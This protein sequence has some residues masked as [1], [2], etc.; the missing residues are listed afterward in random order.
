MLLFSGVLHA[1]TDQGADMA[2]VA[3]YDEAASR[4]TYVLSHAFI[5]DAFAGKL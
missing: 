3:R 5:A 4:Q 2:G 1:Y